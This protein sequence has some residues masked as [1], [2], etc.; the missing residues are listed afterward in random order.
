ML[1]S[2]NQL[3]ISNF[4]AERLK[5]RKLHFLFFALGSILA[6]DSTIASEISMHFLISVPFHKRKICTAP[7]NPLTFNALRYFKGVIKTDKIN[8][9]LHALDWQCLKLERKCKTS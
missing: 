7:G 9:K 4:P 1:F 2:C 5:W 8:L 6:S 3:D